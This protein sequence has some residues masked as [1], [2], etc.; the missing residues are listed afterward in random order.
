VTG[1]YDP[2]T[3]GLL[4]HGKSNPVG[5]AIAPGR[6]SVLGFGRALDADTG[7]L[8][9]HYQSRRT[10]SSIWDSVQVPRLAQ[11][12]WQGKPRK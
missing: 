9:W 8:K 6:Q 11:I 2:E 3:T 5:T 4:G 12:E 10:M 7:K 1:S